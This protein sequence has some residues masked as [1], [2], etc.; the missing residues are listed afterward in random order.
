M[1]KRLNKTDL[2]AEIST[3]RTKLE[4]LLESLSD[5]QL[6]QRG[7]NE[8]DWAIK[9]VLTHLIDWESRGN[10]WYESGKR[11]EEVAV[12]AKGFGWNETKKLNEQIFKRHR[13]KSLT[14][15]RSEFV[16]VHRATIQLIKRLSDAELTELNYYAWTGK[17]WTL[18]DYFR[19]N[20]ASHYKWAT[21][22]IR[23][24]LR[25]Q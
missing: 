24:W 17:S 8:S 16:V 2:L 11:G 15:V 21:K 14:T 1:G 12:P 3:E 6:T 23:K 7:R 9:D 10:G 18:S 25:A 4:H 19:A 22:K 20:T 5:R 13:R